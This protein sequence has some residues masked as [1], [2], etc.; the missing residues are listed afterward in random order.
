[1]TKILI[2]RMSTLVSWI[3]AD[4][5]GVAWRAAVAS[6][7]AFA[8]SE[9]IEGGRGWMRDGFERGVFRAVRG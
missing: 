4:S 1:M 9:G 3:E 2:Y 8:H 5:V 6:V 7:K